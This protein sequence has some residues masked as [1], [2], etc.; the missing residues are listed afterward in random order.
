VSPDIKPVLIFTWGNP[1]RGDDAIGPVIYEKLQQSGVNNFDLLTDFQLQIEH[2]IDLEG[3]KR[4]LFVDASASAKPPF[5][6]CRQSALKDQSYTTHA[7][8]PASLLAV[9]EQV[10][11]RPPPAS[12]LLSVRG[13][14]FGL[15]KPLS[16]GGNRNTVLALSFIQDLLT[17]QGTEAWIALADK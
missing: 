13:Y 14:A 2:A 9:Y 3:R 15:G 8:S 7:M 16:D 6:F 1:S 12:F 10:H 11:R 5:E 17:Q 4:V